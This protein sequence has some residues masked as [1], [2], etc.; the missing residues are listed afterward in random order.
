LGVDLQ[1]E[2]EEE[3]D[4]RWIAE[5]H[6]LPGV[7]VYGANREEALVAVQSLALLVLA[8]RLRTGRLGSELLTLRFGIS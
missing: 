1:I 4:G 2:F 3:D 8:D 7:L 5:I 6:D